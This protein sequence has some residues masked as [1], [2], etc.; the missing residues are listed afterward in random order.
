MTACSHGSTGNPVSASNSA[1]PERNADDSVQVTSN[2]T[3]KSSSKRGSTSR[4]RV[5]EVTLW[6][7]SSTLWLRLRVAQRAESSP[8]GT[9][10]HPAPATLA[11][12]PLALVI[13]QR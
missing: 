1:T 9:R 8:T 7:T 13:G 2:W 4:S 3:L 12:P 6:T 10:I 11:R 5:A